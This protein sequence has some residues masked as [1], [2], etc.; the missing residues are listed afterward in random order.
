MLLLRWYH[1]KHKWVFYQRL[2]ILIVILGKCGLLSEGKLGLGL[3][4]LL[5]VHLSLG[6]AYSRHRNKLQVGLAGKLACKPQEGLLKIVIA[7][8][9]DV[10]VLKVLFAVECNVLGLDFS[11]LDVDLESRRFSN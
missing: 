8:S 7:L 2:K 1:T 9:T 10:V 3:L 6:W 4:D 11:V 5:R